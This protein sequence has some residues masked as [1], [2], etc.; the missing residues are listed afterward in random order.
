MGYDYLS[1]LVS[2][3]PASSPDFVGAKKCGVHNHLRIL[4]DA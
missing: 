3:E 2:F 4:K 1:K